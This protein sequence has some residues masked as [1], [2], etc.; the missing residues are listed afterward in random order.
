MT[1]FDE[2]L[3]T[4][5]IIGVTVKL[6]ILGVT[7]KLEILGGTGILELLG[8]TGKPADNWGYW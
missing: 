7:G 6:D 4:L 8:V 1:S 2:L 3:R 5:K